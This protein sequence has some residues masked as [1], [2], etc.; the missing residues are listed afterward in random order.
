MTVGPLQLLIVGFDDDQYKKDIIRELAK[1]RQKGVIRLLD[2]LYVIKHEDGTIEAQETTQ[3][4]DDE[5]R[6]YGNVIRGLIETYIRDTDS[7]EGQEMLESFR[8]ART[9]FGLDDEELQEVTASIPNGKSAF[10]VLFEHR[11]AV[12]LKEK[13]IEAGAEVLAQGLISPE[14]LTTVTNDLSAVIAAAE[15]MEAAAFEEVK[16]RQAEAKRLE[17]E[18]MAEAAEVVAEAEEIEEKA[19][20]EAAVI[21][22]V[23]EMQ[24][25]EAILDAAETINEADA[26]KFQ[27]ADEA[28]AALVEAHLIQ[29]AAAEEVAE[30]LAEARLIQM[31]AIVQT[32]DT[33]EESE[34]IQAEAIAEAE[35]VVA[36]A[37]AIKAA[38][39]NEAIDA[40][41]AADIIEDVARQR[42]IRA[43]VTAKVIEAKAADMYL[44]GS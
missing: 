15:K 18:A 42:A 20:A 26:L 25:R 6:E 31:R 9:D 4:T 29:E 30:V 2:L 37:E 21:S 23:A 32:V 38:V 28:A 39:I 13:L 41:I 40:M 1:V 17:E 14:S 33:I 10:L 3:L 22:Q 34:A 44:T 19:M 35:E 16:A 36:E 7:L 11:W 27:A 24:K 12:A 8:T 5:K 43:I